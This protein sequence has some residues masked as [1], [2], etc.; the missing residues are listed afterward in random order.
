MCLFKSTVSSIGDGLRVNI[1]QTKRMSEYNWTD[2]IRT[3]L[4]ERCANPKSFDDETIPQPDE[5]QC[6]LDLSAVTLD[7]LVAFVWL[8]IL[9][10]TSSAIKSIRGTGCSPRSYSSPVSRYP[11]HDLRWL[12][13]VTLFLIHLADL[14]DVLLIWKNNPLQVGKVSLVVPICNAFIVILSCVYFDR[15]EVPIFNQIRLFCNS[16]QFLSCLN[17]CRQ[18][19]ENHWQLPVKVV[20][21]RDSK[22]SP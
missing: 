16:W 14:G 3:N 2:W 4:C 18:N 20:V 9:I 6:W 1:Q 10:Y 13:V 8:L 15:I 21:V 11:L 12:L 19:E 22:Q 5:F 17:T 7:L